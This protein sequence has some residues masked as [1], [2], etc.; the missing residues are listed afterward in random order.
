M[1]PE[2]LPISLTAA[3]PA[4][5]RWCEACDAVAVPPLAAALAFGMAQPVEGLVIGVHSRT[6]L[7]ECLAAITQPVALP[8]ASFA[9]NDAAVVDPRQ[10]RK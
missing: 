3:V 4:V 10:W 5:R 2:Q 8:W 1:A 6:H 9:C 7:A